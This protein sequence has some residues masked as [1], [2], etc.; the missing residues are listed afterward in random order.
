MKMKKILFVALSLLLLLA[1][2]CSHDTNNSSVTN[3]NPNTV[4]PTGTVQGIVKDACTQAPIAGAVVDIGVAQA[5]TNANGQYVMRNV[6]AT[7][8]ID[9]TE[10]NGNLTM[11]KDGHGDSGP[12]ITATIDSGYR[13]AYSAT[14]NMANAKIGGVP[15]T[16]YAGFYY[17]E[18]EVAF[19]SLEPSSGIFSADNAD[20][21]PVLGLGNG[22]YDFY[23]GKLNAGITGYAV[24]ARTLQPVVGY[25]VYLIS[26]Y[27][28]N[29][30]NSTTGLSGNKLSQTATTDAAGKF[31]FT[32][33]EANQRF[34]VY[35]V[36]VDTD[37]AKFMGCKEV[38]T[39]CNGTVVYLSDA[40]VIRVSSTDTICPFPLSIKAD[41]HANY[42]DIAKEE[43]ADGVNVVI[44]FSEPIA[45]TE[46]NSGR[47]LLATSFSGSGAF[48]EANLYYDIQVTYEGYKVGNIHHTLTWNAAMTELTVSIPAE[49]LQPASV[50]S[51][52]ILDGRNLKDVNGNELRASVGYFESECHHCDG[53]QGDACVS[54]QALCEG[55]SCGDEISEGN[56]VEFFFTT[57]GARPAAATT[58]RYWNYEEGREDDSQLDYDDRAAL[59]WTAADGAKG[60]NIYCRMIQWNTTIPGTSGC[61]PTPDTYTGQYHPFWLMNRTPVTGKWPLN[62]QGCGSD[63]P[64]S[65]CGGGNN[66]WFE[67]VE[68]WNIKL[69]YECYVVGV[70]AD[71]IEGPESNHVVLEDTNRPYITEV[72]EFSSG[73]EVDSIRV[74]FS[75][76]MNE[77]S[78]ENATWTVNSAAFA[79]GTGIAAVVA[80][81]DYDTYSQCFRVYFDDATQAQL[82]SQ[83]ACGA[84]GW[85]DVTLLS[86]TAGTI[87]DV[88]GNV[89]QDPREHCTECDPMLPVTFEV[90]RTPCVAP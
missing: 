76:P 12:G 35:V 74:C 82:I 27:R 58:L 30:G 60:Y 79:T 17:D 51:V 46:L 84:E 9:Q 63:F 80:Y 73:S 39:G 40:N 57:W 87:T 52:K 48:P 53:C 14:I 90:Y 77:A 66:V 61:N 38:E 67:Y 11:G 59:D 49:A 86:L 18:V 8:Y 85:I 47:G 71:G 32:G 44:K 75:E 43:I 26:H 62:F 23:V 55:Y 88:A 37:A 45:A 28:G 16:N 64:D 33:L 54:C 78:V 42:A 15:V 56:P 70:N 68:S 10:I 5:T 41:G 20:V 22:D 7:S 6:P 34:G 21:T 1:F 4:Y 36:D 83:V 24:D 19:A 25:K 69:S 72:S 29:Q 3:P 50:Y 31:V 89:L 65:Y 13:G 81:K 2:G